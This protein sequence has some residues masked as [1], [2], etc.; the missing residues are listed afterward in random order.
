MQAV[1][2]PGGNRSGRFSPKRAAGYYERRPFV[3]RRSGAGRADPW[4][5]AQPR[6]GSF[7][8]PWPTRPARRGPWRGTGEGRGRKGEGEKGRREIPVPVSPSPFSPAP[9]LPLL[10]LPLEALRLPEPI[11]ALLHSLGVWRIEAVGGLAAARAFF[12]IR[13]GVAGLPGPRD[14]QASRTAAG[15]GPAAAIRGPLVG[16]N[17]PTARR[18]TIEAALEHLVRRLAAMLT[19][20]GRGAMR[21][22]CLLKCTDGRTAASG[23]RAVSPLGL[24]EPPRRSCC[25]CSSSRCNC[26]ARSIR[27]ALTAAST[28]P[29]ELRQQE[30]FSEGRH[31]RSVRIICRA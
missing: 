20:A 9:S 30:M 5:V 24:G 31:A 4:R 6:A 13:A 21:L 18:E 3:R 28:A 10:P 17:S 7:A 1:H 29:L 15:L 22:E 12:A 11:V 23:R 27:S 25:K 26:P 8:P 16:R 2:A 14:G 19:R